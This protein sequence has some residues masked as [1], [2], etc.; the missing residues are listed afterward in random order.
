MVSSY[1]QLV[2]KRYADEL[3]E[4][5]EEFIEFAVDGADRMR[6]MVNA[7]LQYS[8]IETSG[9]PLEPVDLD[10]VVEDALEDLA[11]QIEERDADVTVDPLPRVRGDVNQLRQVFQNLLSNAITYSEDAPRLHVSAERREAQSA[12]DPSGTAAENDGAR[13]VVSVRDE[14][15]GIAPEHQERIFEVFQRLQG[16]ENHPGTGI[17]LALCERIVE[18][19]GGEIWVDSDRGEGSTFSFTLPR[20]SE[21]ED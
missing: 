18:R 3:D 2:E 16:G 17:G 4:D 11:V 21:L 10:G 7:L 14:G 20:A 1:L 9:E 15:I 8:R 13:W 19:H 6:D 12:S 5:G